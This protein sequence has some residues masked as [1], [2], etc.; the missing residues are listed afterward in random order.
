MISTWT[1]LITYWLFTNSL[2]VKDFSPD[3]CVI[4][5]V[6]LLI[7]D[8]SRYLISF[9]YILANETDLRVYANLDIE[10]SQ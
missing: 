6:R 1:E 8:H 7:Y 5:F 3:F 10:V 9:G 4:N 2:P